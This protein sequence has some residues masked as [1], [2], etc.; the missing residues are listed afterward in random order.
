MKQ[1]Q[2]AQ[3]TVPLAPEND[4]GE[5]TDAYSTYAKQGFS[6]N[7]IINACVREI[8]TAVSAPTFLLEKQTAEGGAE[9]INASNN[10]LA[11]ILASPNAEQSQADFNEL[12]IVHLYTTGNA[13]V[14][15]ER[16]R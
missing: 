2:I 5:A 6:G 1:E 3:V 11:A 12:L 7:T 10:E 14:F 16:N 15:K 13:Y 9:Q 4:Y 8:A